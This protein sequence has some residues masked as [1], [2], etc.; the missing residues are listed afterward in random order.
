MADEKEAE[1]KKESATEEYRRRMR[2]AIANAQEGRVWAALDAFLRTASPPAELAGDRDRTHGFY[3]TTTILKTLGPEEGLKA[4][5]AYNPDL[6]EVATAY[7]VTFGR[8]LGKDAPEVDARRVRRAVA[9]ACNTLYNL[10]REVMTYADKGQHHAL[11]TL[12]GECRWCAREVCGDE[13]AANT[14]ASWA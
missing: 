14:G 13:T 9:R 4:A 2:E 5:T 11:T 10:V 8:T 3:R 12:M 1:G 7:L 6:D